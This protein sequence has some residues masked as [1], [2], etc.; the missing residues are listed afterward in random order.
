M[1]EAHNLSTIADVRHGFFT[2]RGGYSH[3]VYNSL[4]CGYG[5]D[6]CRETVTRN[7]VHVARSLGLVVDQIVTVHQMHSPDVVTVTGPWFAQDA[8]EADA[9]VTNGPGT[10]LGVLTADC[11]P[12]LFADREAGVVGAAHAGWRG[13]LAGVCEATV[14]A[15]EALGAGRRHIAAAIGPAISSRN[16]EVGP[17]FHDAFMEK[18]SGSARFFG[19]SERRGH[20]MFDLPGFLLRRLNAAGV[21]SVEWCGKCTYAEEE[22]FF[23]FRRTT[24]REEPDY[25]RQISAITLGPGAFL[26]EE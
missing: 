12:V 19:P 22:D 25:G 16:Y 10:A 15:M 1:I 11:A 17:E 3:G 18:D 8:P 9:M 6:D 14:E 26:K 2:R 7:R 24:H 21:G 4:N 20:F 5:S 13:A 23:S